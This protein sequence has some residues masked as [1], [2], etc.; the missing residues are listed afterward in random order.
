[1]YLFFPMEEGAFVPPGW[2]GGESWESIPTPAVLCSS[3]GTKLSGASCF[4]CP[5]WDWVLPY[6]C[7]CPADSF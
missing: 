6:K 1:M 3:T 5:C 4:Q 2:Q 7:E